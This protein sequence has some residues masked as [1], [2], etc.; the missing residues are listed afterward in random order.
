MLIDLEPYLPHIAP[1]LIGV[2][3]FPFGIFFALRERAW[4]KAQRVGE[5]GRAAA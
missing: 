5:N 1:L 3:A 2:I 4:R